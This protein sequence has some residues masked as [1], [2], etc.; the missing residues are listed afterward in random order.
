MV[1]T[2]VRENAVKDVIRRL[3]VLVATS[4]FLMHVKL[5]LVEQ[6][7]APLDQIILSTFL[8]RLL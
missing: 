3:S 6:R 4:G 1:D 2:R 7:I 8:L 5:A